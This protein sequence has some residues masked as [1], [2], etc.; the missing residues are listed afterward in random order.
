MIHSFNDKLSPQN[1]VTRHSSFTC[2]ETKGVFRGCYCHPWTEVICPLSNP[3]FFLIQTHQSLAKDDGCCRCCRSHGVSFGR[4]KL[5][6][7]NRLRFL[8]AG[9]LCNPVQP[10]WWLGCRLLEWIAHAEWSRI[11]KGRGEEKKNRGE[12]VGRYTQ[13]A[14][15]QQML[16][17]PHCRREKRWK[18]EKGG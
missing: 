3:N 1:F 14:I 17:S 16:L 7:W 2:S 11:K 13:W 12:K 5:L 9:C 8:G 18:W 15:M 10:C 4:E 6:R